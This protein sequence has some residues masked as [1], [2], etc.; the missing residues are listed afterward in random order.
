MIFRVM[1]CAKRNYEFIADLK[2]QPPRLGVA[3][4]M[5]LRRRSTA[6]QAR[7]TRDKSQML[8]RAQ[9]LW[10]AN[11]EGAFVDSRSS[12]EPLTWQLISGRSYAGS[13]QRNGAAL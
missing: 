9:T 5:G 2:T 10:L 13:D 4:V 8:F 1:N 6:N 7:L 12:P 11:G 3:N